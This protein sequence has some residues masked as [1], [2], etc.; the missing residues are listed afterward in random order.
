MARRV[1]TEQA[2]DAYD[3]KGGDHQHYDIEALSD[4]EDVYGA[5]DDYG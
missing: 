3:K 1:Q 4:D 5:E 2:F